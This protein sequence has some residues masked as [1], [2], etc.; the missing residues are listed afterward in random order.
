MRLVGFVAEELKQILVMG[1]D[2]KT[3]FDM[4]I[5]KGTCL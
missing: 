5:Y 3:V 4:A 2:L 1:S